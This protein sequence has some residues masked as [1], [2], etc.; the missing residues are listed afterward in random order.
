MQATAGKQEK[1]ERDDYL[2]R[3]VI[4]LNPKENIER[5][6]KENAVCTFEDETSYMHV[7]KRA[8]YHKGVTRKQ[9]RGWL[10]DEP[11]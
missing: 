2:A 7:K 5:C 10:A 11:R 6:R 9:S 8:A 4:L 3:V 1:L